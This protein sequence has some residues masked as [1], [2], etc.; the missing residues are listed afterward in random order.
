MTTTEVIEEIKLELSGGG[1]LEMEI[2]DETIE[3]VIKKALRE[4]NR[5]WDETSMVTVPFASCIDYT[6]TP[7]E[8]SSSIVKVYRTQGLGVASD[9]NAMSDPLMM[10]QWMVFSNAGTMYNLQDYILNYAAWTTLCQ[11]KNTLPISRRFLNFRRRLSTEFPELFRLQ[12]C[13]KTKT[14]KK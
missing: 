1:L 10:Q 4:L 13:W 14:L 8:E 7:L 5:F 6:G 3:S 11:V 9:V 2:E 12:S